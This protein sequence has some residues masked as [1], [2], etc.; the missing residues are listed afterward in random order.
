MSTHT[1]PLSGLRVVELA[2]IGPGPHA[3]MVLADLGAQVVRIDRPSGGLQVGDAEAPDPTLRGRRRVAADLKDPAGRETV[4]RLVEHADVLLEGYRPGVTERLGVGPADCHARNPRLVYARM[5]GWGQDGPMAQRA[6]HDINY[7]SL[8][9]ALHAIGRAGERPVPPLN[10]VGDFGGGSMLLVVGVL[11][12][13]WEAE[14]SGQGQVVD[15]AMVDGASLLVQMVWGLLGQGVWRDERGVNLLDGHTPFYDTYTCADGRYVAVGALE[16]QFYAAFLDGLGLDQAEL[17]AQYDQDGW[18]VL[19]ARFTEVLATRTRDEWAKLFDG[20]DA[21]VT[22]VLS[23]A[24]AASHPHLDARSTIVAP[25]GVAQ[26]APAPRFSRTPGRLPSLSGDTE[27]VAAVLADWGR[28]P[29]G[30][31]AARER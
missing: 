17:P 10:L 28:S 25:D 20:T 7:I 31:A 24:E 26:A 1:G 8:T 13:L 15:A 19:R 9:G 30:Q 4:L 29:R 6:G 14:R 23:F 27:D 16:P 21:C 2:G 5:T 11:A 12:A 18:P 22:P 3:A